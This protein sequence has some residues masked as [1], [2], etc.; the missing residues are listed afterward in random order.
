MAFYNHLI[1]DDVKKLKYKIKFG[2]GKGDIHNILNMTQSGIDES[3]WKQ[4][5]IRTNS[6]ENQDGFATSVL[7]QTTVSGAEDIYKSQ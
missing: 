2:Y 5:T 6:S 3:E 7:K 1:S 4:W